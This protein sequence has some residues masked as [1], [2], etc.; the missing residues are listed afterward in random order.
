MYVYT[1]VYLSSAT[2]YAKLMSEETLVSDGSSEGEGPGS[3]VEMVG[4]ASGDQRYE[5]QES[6]YTVHSGNDTE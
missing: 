6:K 2:G 4:G 3:K 5:Q 1:V